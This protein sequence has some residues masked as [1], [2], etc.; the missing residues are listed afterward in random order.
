MPLLSQDGCLRLQFDQLSATTLVHLVSG[1]DEDTPLLATDGASSTSIS[2]Y[3]EWVNQGRA[4]LTIGWDFQLLVQGT[5]LTLER[6]GAPRSNI[7]LL[8][9][10]SAELGPEAA[11]RL[12]ARFV[13]ALA[14]QDITLDA[15]KLRYKR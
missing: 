5:V 14:W 2:G 7:I 11:D 8:D 15:I 4:R 3:T 10:A 13:D 1:L 6:L 12:L 9:A